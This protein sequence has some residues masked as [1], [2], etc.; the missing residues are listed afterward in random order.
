MSFDFSVIIAFIILFWARPSHTLL[1]Q[2]IRETDSRALVFIGDLDDQTE[3]DIGQIVKEVPI[4]VSD[5]VSESKTIFESIEN[6]DNLVFIRNRDPETVSDILLSANATS[7]LLNVVIVHGDTKTFAEDT[8]EG[9]ERKIVQ[10]RNRLGVKSQLYFIYQTNNLNV[11]QALG[12]AF[13]PPKLSVNML[14]DSTSNN[15]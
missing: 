12:Q 10:T 8:M 9:Y 13:N 11:I 15:A 14:I 3:F 4:T 5:N 1:D 2:I 7:F 6:E